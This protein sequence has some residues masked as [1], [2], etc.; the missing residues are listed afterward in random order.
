MVP[1]VKQGFA[2]VAD[3]ARLP[4]VS[5][6]HVGGLIAVVSSYLAA[7]YLLL[8]LSLRSQHALDALQIQASYAWIP[9]GAYERTCRGQ[10]RTGA[11]QRCCTH[12]VLL[13]IYQLVR[14]Y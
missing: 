2:D 8:L 13:C 10:T 9:E 12:Q 3:S 7:P 1:A 5:R 11:I 6:T 4:H 14:R